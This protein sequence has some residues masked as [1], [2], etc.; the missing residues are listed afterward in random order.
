[1]KKRILSMLLTATMACSM[2]PVT[3]Q[4]AGTDSFGEANMTWIG[5]QTEYQKTLENMFVDG[6]RKMKA[7]D[8]WG[9]VDAT[10]DWVTPRFMTKSSWNT[11]WR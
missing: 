8:K 10:G 4:A 1:M 9:I 3:A 7:G 5:T 2:L 6:M 11:L